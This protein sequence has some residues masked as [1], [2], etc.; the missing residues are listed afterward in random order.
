MSI[1]SF[2]QAAKQ[3]VDWF[4]KTLS[5]IRIGVASPALVENVMVECYGAKTPLIQLASIQV[6]EPRTLVIQPWD[7]SVLKDIERALQTT[8]IGAAPVVEGTIVRI[9]IPSLTEDRR[10]EVV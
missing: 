1:D 5:E 8:N 3:S 9:S 7:K 2:E 4:S 10:R 6:P